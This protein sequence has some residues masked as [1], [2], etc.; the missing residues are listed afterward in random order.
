[1]VLYQIIDKVA[2]SPDYARAH[3]SIIS[4][5]FTANDV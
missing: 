1:L 4:L 2:I 3:F 5:I